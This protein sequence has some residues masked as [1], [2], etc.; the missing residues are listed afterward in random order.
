MN[1]PRAGF[2]RAEKMNRVIR[3]VAEKQCDGGAGAM[4]RA[5]EARGRGIDARLKIDKAD[6]P[7]AELDRGAIAISAH[8]IGQQPRQGAPRDRRVPTDAW[9]VVFLAGIGSSHARCA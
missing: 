3:R 7:T 6:W 5:R 4:A 9:W 8:G 2:Q 1:Q